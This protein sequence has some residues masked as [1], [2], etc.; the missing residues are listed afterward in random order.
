MHFSHKITSKV[1]VTVFRTQDLS[2]LSYHAAIKCELV[3]PNVTTGGSEQ[4]IKLIHRAS[5][6]QDVFSRLIDS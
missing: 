1:I 2:V 5:V 3:T 6:F 4:I